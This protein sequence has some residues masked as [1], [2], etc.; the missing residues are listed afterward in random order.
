[1][2]VA[3][4][5]GVGSTFSFVL[6]TPHLGDTEVVETRRNEIDGVPALLVTNDGRR[7]PILSDVLVGLGLEVT[8]VASIEFAEQIL[9]DSL[10]REHPYGL[11]LIDSDEPMSLCERLRSLPET[12][13]T[14]L[15]VLTANGRRGDGARC[16]E[17]R[18]GAYLTQPLASDDISEAISQ[19]LMGPAP[20]DLTVLVTRHWL[21]ERRRRLGVLVV[22]DSATHRMNLTRLFERRGHRVMTVVSGEAA[23]T[24]FERHDYDVVIMDIVMPGIGG[25]EAIRRLRKGWPDADAVI[26]AVTIDDDPAVH[27]DVMDAGADALLLRPFDV[28]DL[29]NVVD[30]LVSIPAS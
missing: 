29:F 22:D 23:L 21:R 4:D 25:V 3:S 15:A 8:T 11:V 30:D 27:Q 7:A 24:E 9:R 1:M 19:V 5:V 13:P 28:N 6:P 16:R 14:H 12:A 2:S 18:V 10:V 26:V 20:D 17:L